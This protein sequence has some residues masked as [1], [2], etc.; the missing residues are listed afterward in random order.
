MKISIH[1]RTTSLKTK[2]LSI[3]LVSFLAHKDLRQADAR[4]TVLHQ[5]IE[6]I[7][8][9]QT[10]LQGSWDLIDFLTEMHT[11]VQHPFVDFFVRK[12]LEQEP[13]VLPTEL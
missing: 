1:Q 2:E 10:A 6:L 13:S 3:S 4:S 8:S 9:T 7:Q 12:L 11:P 5:T